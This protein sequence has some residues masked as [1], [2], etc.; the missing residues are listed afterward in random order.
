VSISTIHDVLNL[1][2]DLFAGFSMAGLFVLLLLFRGER[3]VA[4]AQTIRREE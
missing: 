4:T 2:A 3:G 1:F